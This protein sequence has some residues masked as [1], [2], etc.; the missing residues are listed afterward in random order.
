MKN[1]VV[2]A[3]AEY[4]NCDP[5]DITDPSRAWANARTRGLAIFIASCISPCKF[6]EIAR[7][8]RRHQAAVSRA[9]KA[10]EPI[11]NH[12]PAFKAWLHATLQ[13]IAKEHPTMVRLHDRRDI[14]DSTQG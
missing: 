2:S 6:S 1:A 11:Y 7:A 4:N 3:A 13:R 9:L 10:W 12:D 8:F 5:L 14:E